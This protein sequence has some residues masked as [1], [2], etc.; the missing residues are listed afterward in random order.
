[1]SN[2]W[3]GNTIKFPLGKVLNGIE[4]NTMDKVDWNNVTL[5]YRGK[6]ISVAQH[7]FNNELHIQELLVPV[8]YEESDCNIIDDY[9]IIHYHDNLSSFINVLAKAKDMIDDYLDADTAREISEAQL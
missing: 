9:T 8:P 2:N 5:R 7:S 6:L 4:E 1:M 3:Y